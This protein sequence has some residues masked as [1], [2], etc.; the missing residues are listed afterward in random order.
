MVGIEVTQLKKKYHITILCRFYTVMALSHLAGLG[1]RT[2]ANIKIL[3]PVEKA[4]VRQIWETDSTQKTYL[5]RTWAG[6]NEQGTNKTGQSTVCYRMSNEHKRTNERMK[7][8]NN[9]CLPDT[10][11]IQR[12]NNEQTVDIYRTIRTHTN[13]YR[14]CVSDTL[15]FTRSQV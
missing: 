8:M 5:Q 12:M 2:S 11:N 6:C 9:K 3:C 1:Q 15:H 4:P 7:R 10:T 13:N 14:T